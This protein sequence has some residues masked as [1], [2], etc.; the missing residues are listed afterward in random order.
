MS[1]Q[2]HSLE[3][4]QAIDAAHYLHPFTDHKDLRAAGSRMITRANGSF[5]YDSEGHEILD[6]MA[7]LW[8][9]NIGYGRKELAEVAARQME[10]LAYYNTC[11]QTTHVPAIGQTA[12]G[13]SAQAYQPG[14]LRLVRFGIERHCCSS[15][16]ALLGAAGQAAE[17][18]DH[19][20]HH[21]L[22]WLDHHRRFARRHERDA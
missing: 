19:F 9:V 5:I 2:N 20:P 18:P 6:G 11:F 8:C 13:A 3:Q 22:S 17:K 16:A 4:L 1:Y 12:G 21:G 15:S 14:V 7:G 10:E